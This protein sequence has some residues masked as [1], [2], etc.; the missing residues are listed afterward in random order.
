MYLKLA[1]CMI[2][3]VNNMKCHKCKFDNIVKATYCNNCGEKFTDKEKKEAYDKTIYGKI[4][5]LEKIKDI[6]TLDVI[7][8]NIVFKICSLL[9]VLGIGIYFLFTMGWNTKILDSKNYK[10][11]YNTSDNRY[12]I[13]VDDSLNSV[14]VLLYRP[15]R[16]K[17]MIVNHYDLD[18][19][20]IDKKEIKKEEK[21]ELNTSSTDYYVIESKYGNKKQDKIKVAVYHKSDI[22]N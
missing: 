19:N 20:L 6:A 7:T 13:V 3:V 1:V 18:N 9:I 17:K 8:G 11:F 5:K 4:E 22:A 15:N 21:V 2:R 16:L 14:D 10:L 12:Y